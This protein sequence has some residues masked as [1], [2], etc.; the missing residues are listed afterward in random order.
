MRI[1]TSQQIGRANI[2]TIQRYHTLYVDTRMSFR[3]E[4]STFASQAASYQHGSKTQQGIGLTTID[5]LDF[6]KVSTVL[7]LG[8]GTGCL[9][10]VLS[11]R[12]GP[13]G[14]V[15]AV[16]PDGE[17]L[18]V[19]RE[20]YPASNIE[21]IQADDQTFLAGQYDLIFSNIVI[22]WIHDKRAL[23]KRVYENLRP[24]GCFVFT[25]ANGFLP[26]PE[27]G[28]KLFNELVGPNFLPWML[29]EKMVF[30][31]ASEYKTLASD[32]G[33]RQI[34]M[35]AST[36]NPKWRNLDDYIDSMYGWFQGEFDPTQFD[37]DTLQKLKSKHGTGSITQSE[38]IGILHAVLTKPRSTY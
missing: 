24:G 18:K 8:C 16:D 36:A 25:T 38:P 1:L 32:I 30:W 15:V 31:N 7:D 3:S 11:E 12:V 5:L 9:T 29:N 10:N 26:V 4:D 6:E 2:K 34:S 37:G 13:E 35:T 20:Q 21:Y 27:I 33:F 17:R 23:Y 14:K 19:A 22:H 28:K